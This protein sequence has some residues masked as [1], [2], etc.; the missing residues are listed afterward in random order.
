MTGSRSSSTR[1]TDGRGELDFTRTAEIVQRLLASY[2]ERD[3][4]YMFVHVDISFEYLRGFADYVKASG[5]EAFL[6]E[7]WPG[8]Q[9]AYRYCQSILDSS[10]GLPQIPAGREG[11]EAF[12]ASMGFAT[13]MIAMERPR[14]K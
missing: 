11:A 7:Q 9:A 4:P 12:F 13:S 8:I 3:Y 6:K 2:T 14:L 10:T 1:L 5:D